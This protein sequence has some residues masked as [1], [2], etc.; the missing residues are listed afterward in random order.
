[1]KRFAMSILLVSGAV[2]GFAVFLAV[3]VGLFRIHSVTLLLLFCFF[4]GWMLFAY[5]H[6]RHG[7]QAEFVRLLVTVT[8]AGAPLAPAL[9]SY[10]RDRP[11]GAAREFFVAVLLFFV[12]PGYY[13]VWHRRHSYDR[14]LADLADL[15]EDG[16]PLSEALRYVPGL[17]TRD[18][19]LA[20]AVGEATGQLA[21]CLRASTPAGL[22]AVWVEV[23]PR[24]IYPPLLLLFVCGVTVFWSLFIFP[25]MQK[26]FRDFKEPLPTITAFVGGLGQ[27]LTQFGGFLICPL[28][29]AVPIAA[30]VLLNTRAPVWYVPILGRVYRLSVQ[31]RVLRMLGVLLQ[32]GRPVPEALTILADS[33]AFPRRANTLLDS[34]CRAVERGEPLADSLRQQGLLQAGTVPLVRAAERA[35]NL[36]RTL[37]EIGEALAGRLAR[38]L[39]RVSL[40]V[41][42]LCLLG[43]GALV[44]FIGLGMYFPLIK[45]LTRL[46]E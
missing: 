30:V 36:P 19:Q 31:S 40:A 1:M 41:M 35:Q 13:W 7:R 46:T 5:L 27:A 43:V 25:K 34:T 10:L 24:F 22:A 18:T 38:L 11:R 20:A 26:I 23:L 4:Y 29:T 2:L 42:P 32:A 6:Y 3:F 28:L 21:R 15:L 14:K 33:G 8:E 44:G 39:R 17:A 9:R 45:L 16:Y 12:V 37:E